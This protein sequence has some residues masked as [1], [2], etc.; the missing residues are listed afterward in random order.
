MTHAVQVVFHTGGG[1]RIGLGYV[2]RRLSLA[3]ALRDLG[4]QSLFLLRL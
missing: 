2:R 1:R 4:A 3:L